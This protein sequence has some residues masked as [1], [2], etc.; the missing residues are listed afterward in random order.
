MRILLVNPWI[1]DFAAYDFW[2]KP[3]GLLYLG[4]Y[5]KALGHEVFLI[6]LLNRHDP[7]LRNFVRVPKDKFYGT[8]KFPSKV[9]EKPEVLSGIP[10]KF[11]R[12]GAPEEFFERRLESIG[13]IDLVMVTSSM[14]YWYHGV[15]K[16][17]EFLKERLNVPIVLGGIYTRILPRHAEKSP[18]DLVFHLSDLNVLNDFLRNRIGMNIGR[19]D[20]DWFSD[21]DP[22]YELYERVGYLVFMTSLGCPFNC[23]YCMTPKM[24]KFKKRDPKRVVEGIVRY[25]EM[26]NVEDVVFFDDAFLVN[27]KHVVKLL[28]NLI[29][30][31]L[32][33]RYHLPNG[34]HARLLDEEIANLMKEAN[35][36]TVKLG[37]ETSGY[38][39]E[40]TGGKV[41]DEDLIRAVRIL[42]R[43]GFTS[44]EVSAY[45]MINMP[46]QSPEDVIEAVNVCKKVGIRVNLNEY[47][48]IP[49]TRDWYELVSSGSIDPD[50]DPLLLNNSILPFWWKGGMDYST[51][52]KLK[53]YTRNGRI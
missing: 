29:G 1:H 27:R 11:K 19:C 51:V 36:K 41:Y 39:Q 33:V 17:I 12:Y 18:A 21:L 10:R 38:L 46:G 49:G 42:K 9:I 50:V 13:R 8:G 4:A 23:T 22:A 28:K 32:K 48:P 37:Y 53:E 47:T 5:L 44:E 3:L 14:T 43:V 15:W 31:K 26:F 34:V 52:E 20:C 45:V 30:A 35:F 2:L 6:D 40:K 16:T 25:V 24:W 7:E